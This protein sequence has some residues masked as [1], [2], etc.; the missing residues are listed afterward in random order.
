[1]LHIRQFGSGD[2]LVA[3]HGFSLTGSQFADLGSMID[4]TII[5][6]DLPGHGR[7]VDEASDLTSAVTAVID[8]LSGIGTPTPMLGYSQG[9]RLALLTALR[10]PELVSALVLISGTAGIRS[11]QDRRNRA[12]QDDAR[13]ARI[14]LLGL[15]RFLDEWTATGITSTEHLGAT[16]RRVDRAV[17]LENTAEGLAAALRGYGQGTQPVVWDDLRDLSC[18][19]LLIAGA[20]DER[21]AEIAAAMH[22]LLPASEMVLI[23]GSGHNPLAD[24]PEQATD[25]ISAFLDRHR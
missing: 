2:A 6:P 14:E 13:A 15:E 8:V 25:A 23:D 20:N 24:Q 7:S 9:A 3:L 11:E 10:R 21:Y 5:A 1:M 19:T 12:T 17:R 18:P 16:A 22:R 4:R